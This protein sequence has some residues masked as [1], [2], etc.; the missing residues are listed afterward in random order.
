MAVRILIA[1]IALAPITTMAEDIQSGDN[2]STRQSADPTD[3]FGNLNKLEQY[4]ENVNKQ[5]D[6]RL[7]RTP[8][9]PFADTALTREPSAGR[10]ENSAKRKALFVPNKTPNGSHQTSAN[11]FS[12]SNSS[13]QRDFPQMQFKGFMMIAGEKAGLLDITGLGTFVVKEGDKVGLQQMTNDTVVRIVE[14]NALN[15]IIE[16]GNLGEKVVVQ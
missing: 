8:R 4:Y 15:L 3:L 5:L 13:A 11:T 6:K 16:F 7:S 10:D 2:T 9:D 14:I 1:V 12:S